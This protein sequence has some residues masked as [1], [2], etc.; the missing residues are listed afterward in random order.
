MSLL[1]KRIAATDEK[2]NA[3][4][5]ARKAADKVRRQA[6]KQSKAD[7]ERKVILVGEAVLRRVEQGQWDEVEFRNMMDESL[8]R[9]ADRAL[10][11]LE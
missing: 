2:L 5:E 8:T 11:D 6:Y 4:K 9:G 7:R 10:F 3:I 1:R